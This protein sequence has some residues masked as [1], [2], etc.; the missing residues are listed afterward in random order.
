MESPLG[1]MGLSTEFPPKVGADWKAPM[2]FFYRNFSNFGQKIHKISR[3]HLE[4][5]C[6]KQT[7]V[8]RGCCHNQTTYRE[9]AR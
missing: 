3:E 5:S 7:A 9:L 2:I 8:L 4:M 1:S 6:S